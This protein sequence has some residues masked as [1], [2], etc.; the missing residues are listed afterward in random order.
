[1]SEHL[2]RRKFLK[3]SA[4]TPV[5]L[6]AV[7]KVSSK[8]IK[9]NASGKK[10][11]VLFIMTDQQRYD[12]VGANNNKIIKTPHLDRL[13]SQSANFS[14]AYVQAP[15]CVPS[16]ASF[17]TGR[18]AHAHQ[19][20][21]NYTPINDQTKFFP[22]Y[23]QDADYQTALIGKL[24]LFYQHP[25]SSENA[26]KTGFD[27]VEL[28]DGTSRTDKWSDYVVWR[29]QRDPNKKHH[30]RKLVAKP[31]QFK[32]IMKQGSNPFL[33]VI[34]D[35]YT[36]TSWTG[37]RTR[38]TI[39]K[40]AKDDKPFFLYSSFWKPH[41]PFEVPKPF[42]TLYNDVVFDL[43]KQESLEDIQ[44]LPLPLQKLIL[45]SKKPSYN[46]DRETL[47]W[48]YRS[49]YASITHIDREV[50]LI[51]K[52][53]EE[54]GQADNTIIV[55]VSDHGDQ[56]LEHGLMGKN[57]FFDASVRVPLMIH[58]K[59][60][61]IS[62]QFEDLVETIDVFP[63]LMELCN[64]PVPENCHGQSL[65]N[66]VTNNRSQFAPRDAVFSENIIPEVIT[67]GNLDFQFVPGKGIKGIRHPD[68]KMIRTE[69]WKFNYYPEGF[70]E[71]Y[72]LK[73]DPLEQENLSLIP[74]RQPIVTEF[75]GRILDWLITAT[76]TDQ[77]ARRWMV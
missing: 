35:Q 26:K 29:N 12:C 32:K 14:H 23:L 40:M 9:K 8:E 47:Q 50:G 77:I 16:R 33:S 38:E 48:I 41:S 24:H 31:A 54:T 42:D 22:S 58:Y 5:V 65:V 57:V 53:L 11:N 36:D 74:S 13:A 68:A 55:F 3:T 62:G 27:L 70:T 43:P 10:P 2:S 28:H 61:I 63:T 45:R 72:D 64:L 37:L 25:P 52:T 60:N 21:V 76:E 51:L 4:A 59:N 49:Y 67:S 30:Y 19:N 75:K 1:M 56:L 20:R 7:N 6:S 66:L 39:K 15:V 17:F 69:K 73:N 34:D 18:Y 46:M 71:L 44:K